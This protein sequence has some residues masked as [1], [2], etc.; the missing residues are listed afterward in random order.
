MYIIPFNLLLIAA[1]AISLGL[2]CGRVLR[3]LWVLELL[4][5]IRRQP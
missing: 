3:R 5:E 2:A 4:A 1:G